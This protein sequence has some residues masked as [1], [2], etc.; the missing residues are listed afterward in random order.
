MA[1]PIQLI[2]GLGN[3]GPQYDKTRHNAGAWFVE[4]LVEQT[5][6]PMR[7]E[8]KFQGL[9]GKLQQTDHAC[10]CLLPTTFM[11]HSGRAIRALAQF[12]QIEP[13]AI[14]VAHDD[15]DLPAGS[16]KL[17]RGGGHGGHNG[18]RDTIAQLG[19]KDFLRLRFGIAHP[20]DKDKVHDYVLGR[21]SKADRDLKL[22]AIDSALRYLPEL[23][24]GDEQAVMK[25]LHTA[26]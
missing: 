12:Y 19:S 3:P 18:L 13:Q 22:Q 16:V 21:P 17:K 4:Q 26:T 20:G 9:L 1:T 23:L 10:Y 2:V 5:A 15:L 8:K 6:C 14:C 25:H 11:N 7:A 24:Q